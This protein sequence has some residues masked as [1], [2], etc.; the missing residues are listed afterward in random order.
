MLKNT[1]VFALTSTLVIVAISQSSAQSSSR[2]GYRE[3]NVTQFV[4]QKQISGLTPNQTAVKLFGYPGEAEGRNAENVEVKYPASN[5]AVIMLT[6]EGLA[7]D[8]VNSLRNRVEMRRAQNSKW[9]IVWVGEQTK[10]Q[11][12][13]GS[14]TWTAKPCL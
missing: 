12:G 7:D 5:T 13:R 4:S 10:C 2:T 3:V 14:Q 9:Q 1:F 6:Q 8:S 11:K